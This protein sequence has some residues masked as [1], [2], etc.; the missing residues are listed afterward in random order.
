MKTKLQAKKS[1]KKS[2][3][4]IGTCH[5]STEQAAVSYYAAYGYSRRD[6]LN[7]IASGEIQ[8]GKP[9][10]KPGEVLSLH[11]KEGRYFLT[12]NTAP[13]YIQKH[14]AAQEAGAFSPW[15]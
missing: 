3:T 12:T 15:K 14:A 2:P 4:T 6:V 11:P 1:T 8:I 9:T 10:T 5:F 7:K 13:A